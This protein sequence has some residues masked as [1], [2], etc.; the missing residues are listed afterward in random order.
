M[1]LIKSIGYHSRTIYRD[2]LSDPL[3]KGHRLRF[4]KNYMVWQLFEKKRKSKVITLK[5]GMKTIVKPVPD[6]D[7]GEI[8]I[9]THNM[10]Y[11]DTEFVRTFLKKGD[12][13]IDA[14]CNVGNR[15]LALAD[16]IEGA[17]LIDAGK[18]A[19]ER[20]MQHIELNGLASDKFIVIR[21]AVGEKEGVIRFTDY[22]GASTQN[23]V[24][25]GGTSDTH[26]VEVEM[27]TLDR[28]VERY[29]ISP[30]FIK[31]D[32]EGQDLNALRGGLHTLESG[33]VKLVKFEHIG[34]T[35]LQPVFDF[36]DSIGWKV[37]GLDDA[38][39]SP[40][41]EFKRSS[42]LNLFAMPRADFAK[43]FNK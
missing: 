25:L 19:T 13:I 20:T 35:P 37:F 40:V 22:G 2:I 10:D 28:E 24:I 3:N 16:I 18:A 1:S 36:F 34:D 15:T 32:V 31:T 11:Y 38:G 17:L 23:R 39:K 43:R 41:E 12:Y 27:T 30:V 26:I 42:D 4:L 5:N 29:R 8:G 9:W 21:K 7:A 33:C 14:G 6:N